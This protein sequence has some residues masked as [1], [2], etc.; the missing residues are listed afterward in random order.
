M[1]IKA[2]K[3]SPQEIEQTAIGLALPLVDG[4]GFFFKVNYT[5][6]DQI[7]TNIR[8]L[9]LT[10]KGERV[11]IP[12]YGCDLKKTLFEQGANAIDKI[13]FVVSEALKKWLPEVNV[14]NLDVFQSALDEH[15]I[16]IKLFYNLP[17]N[18]QMVEEVNLEVSL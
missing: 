6:S 7:K 15:V 13:Q 10:N 11:M 3:I 9:L 18:K 1:K 16:M 8:N 5:T 2:F 17:Y 14:Q 4:G 12:A